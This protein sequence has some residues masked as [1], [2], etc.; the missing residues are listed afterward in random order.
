MN[1]A[2]LILAVLS[3][4]ALNAWSQSVVTS[5][6]NNTAT[7]VPEGNLVGV[8]EPLDVSGLSGVISD[9]MVQLDITGGVNGNL[10]VF[11][12]GPGGQLSVLL[13]RPGLSAGNPIGYSDAGFD[14]TLDGQATN[15]IHEYQSGAYTTQ[16]GQLTGT[17][18]ADGRDLN[19]Q[20]SGAAFDASNPTL[21][22]NIF[23]GLAGASENGMW[24]LFVAD[25]AAGGGAPIIDQVILT[26]TTPEP[27]T[28]ALAA[29]AL[30]AAYCF[31]RR[32]SA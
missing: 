18:A 10:Y 1:K 25:V 29:T 19:P 32:T 6:T 2:T 27:A 22:L 20:S 30:A 17:W 5:F 3:L 13:N 21:G 8:T 11:L 24:T 28:L 9:V 16:A 12:A 14:I 23:D 7:V 15:N 31:R 4:A 26:V